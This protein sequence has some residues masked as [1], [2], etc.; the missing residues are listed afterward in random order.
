MKTSNEGLDL[1]KSFEGCRLTSYKDSVGVWTIGYGHTKGVRANQTITESVATEYLRQD[2]ETAEAA[3]MKYDNKYHWTQNQFDALVSFAFNVGSIHQLT[4]YGKRSIAEI[5]GAIPLYCKAGGRTLKGLVNRRTLEKVMFDKDYSKKKMES[6]TMEKHE[7]G[8]APVYDAGAIR[9]FQTACRAEN[10]CGKN[11]KPLTVDGTIGPNTT[12]AIN[13]VRLRFGGKGELVKFLQMRINTV[14]GSAI[15]ERFG[16]AFL[17]DGIFSKEL[18]DA[19]I[20]FQVSRGLPGDGI[21]GYKTL[22]ELMKLA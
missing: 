17:P 1:I 7:G 12:H 4:N 5:S 13:T 9:A 20:M 11:K 14:L 3:V 21:V 10:I 15:I 2:L 16:K 8:T 6:A 19:V 22:T 18:R